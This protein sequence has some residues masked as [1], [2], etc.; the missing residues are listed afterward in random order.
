MV[1]EANRANAR[2]WQCPGLRLRVDSMRQGTKQPYT[3]EN[4]KTR[5]A[6]VVETP[7]PAGPVSGND[8]TL[9]E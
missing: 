2:L 4:S 9:P 7:F 8:C 3:N 6:S 5:G 1:K